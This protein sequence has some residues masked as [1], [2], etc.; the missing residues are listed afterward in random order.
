VGGWHG[1]D[2]LDEPADTLR[3]DPHHEN[4]RA[5]PVQQPALPPSHPRRA[6][7]SDRDASSGYPTLP[8]EIR[9]PVLAAVRAGRQL[10]G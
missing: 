2:A 5:C 4:G 6:V 7:I 9:C 3:K 8:A 10:R 1:R